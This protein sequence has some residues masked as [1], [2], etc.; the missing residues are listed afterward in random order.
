MILLFKAIPP[1]SSAD[2]EIEKMRQIL[3]F[4]VKEA[5]T[6]ED[7][8]HAEKQLAEFSAASSANEDA[9]KSD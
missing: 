8:E 9:E 5:K 7:R 3:L 1:A 4:H 2:P 6:P